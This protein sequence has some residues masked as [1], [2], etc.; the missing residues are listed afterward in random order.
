[1]DDLMYLFAAAV[2]LAAVLA[3][4]GIWAPRRAWV[5]LGAL[6][7]AALFIPLAYATAAALLSRPKPAS[8]EWARAATEEAAVLGSSIHEGQAIYV[9]LQM[10]E[11]AE[12][13]AYKL[14]WNQ[15]IAQQ[16]E[17]A[18]REAERRG[19]GMAMRLPF[20]KSWDSQ[21]PKF[22]ALPQPQLPPKDEP[23]SPAEQV[24][25]PSKDA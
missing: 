7:V 8:L 20:E 15:A 5:R 21:E 11:A 22:Y 13:R 12:P 18:R 14:P 2:V 25:H 4:I 16:L 6:L 17:E 19:S 9:W 3:N 24:Q 23:D 10:R 1:M